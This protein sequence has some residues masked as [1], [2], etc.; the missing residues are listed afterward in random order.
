MIRSR[1]R[2]KLE[3]LKEISD[4]EEF[5]DKL[6]EILKDILTKK[7]VFVPN[8]SNDELRDEFFVNLREKINALYEAMPNKTSIEKDIEFIGEGH[9]SLALRVC[10]CVLKIS[11]EKYIYKQDIDC[12]ALCP[13]FFKE[14]FDVDSKE[15][16]IVTVTP[17]VEVLEV[18]DEELYGVY[19]EIRSVGYIWNDPASGN[20]GRIINDITYNGTTY[21][22]GD[23]VLIDHEDLAFV[24]EDTPEIVLTE[25]EFNSYNSKTYQF[26]TR[27]LREKGKSLK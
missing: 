25:I 27:Y 12:R 13:I 18:S 7:T 17:R 22:K 16:Y 23:Y 26:E 2:A 20:I 24:G 9:T 1:S 10:D 14:R 3:V 11:K 21:K 15:H 5:L 19:K 6:V 8:S 4:K